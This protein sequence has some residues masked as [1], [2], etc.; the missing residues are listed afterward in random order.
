MKIE[1]L[2]IMKDELLKTPSFE[3]YMSPIQLIVENYIKEQNK[4]QQQE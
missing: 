3:K 4:S 2:K 1:D